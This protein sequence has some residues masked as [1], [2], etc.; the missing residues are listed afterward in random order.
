[1]GDVVGRARPHRR[2]GADPDRRLHRRRRPPG[3]TAGR[4][5]PHRGVVPAVVVGP[6]RD[7]PGGRLPTRPTGPR[8][9]AVGGGAVTATA[10]LRGRRPARAAVEGV[11]GREGLDV[12]AT[13]ALALYSFVAALGFARV[14]ADWQFVRDIAVIVIVGHGSALV[15]RR[16]RVP[17]LLAVLITAIPL[18][19]AVAW[20]AYPETFTA[21]LPTRETWDTGWADLGLVRAQFQNTVAPVEYIGGWTLLSA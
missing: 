7:H 15:L 1:M 20:V 10:R 12:V 6:G 5:C 2:S 8:P 14:F 9:G 19:W 17:G 11:D 16:L 3:A 4:R 18:A 21:F 13:L